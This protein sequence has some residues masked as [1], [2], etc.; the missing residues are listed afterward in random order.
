MK[1]VLSTCLFGALALS[2]AACGAKT[3]T[4]GEPVEKPQAVAEESETAT[5]NESAHKD[6]DGSGYSDTGSGVFGL[7]NTSGATLDGA[8]VIVYV[9]D[10]AVDQVGIGFQSREMDG[11]VL[12]YI[13]ADGLLNAKEQVSDTDGSLILQGSLL[14]EGKHVV[15]A[16][17]YE[18]DD[19]AGEVKT[20]KSAEYTVVSKTGSGGATDSSDQK[21]FDGS[22]YSD[23]G[24]GTFGLVNE[25]GSTL[26][27]N[28]V[29]VYV[30]DPYMEIISIGIDARGMDGSVLTFIYIDGVLN[31]KEQLGDTSI[32][33][34]LQETELSE[35]D[36]I[37]EAVQYENDDPAAAVKTY[38]SAVY[39]VKL[40]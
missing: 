33:T 5:V 22:A 13:Y 36:H 27:G 1:K 39:T 26:E 15:E 34:Y 40:K 16:V 3:G 29:V 23:M 10:P 24:P 6:F 17:Q 32:S 9:N 12:T 38:K 35:G 2:L 25:S 7:I 19:P 4:E 11:A 18:N 14:S 8:E 20:Y 31:T 28:S 37:V 30:E 21:G